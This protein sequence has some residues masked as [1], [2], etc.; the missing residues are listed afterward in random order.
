M[1]RINL[2]PYKGTKEYFQI[3]DVLLKSTEITKDSFLLENGIT[4]S[5]YRLARKQEQNIGKSIIEILSNKFNYKLLQ[6]EK[7]DEIEDKIN[8]IYFDMYYK[9]FKNYDEHIKYLDDLLKENYLIFPILKLMKLFLLL[10]TGKDHKQ[11]E[12][13]LTPIF[14]EIKKYKSFFVSGLDIIY[15]IVKIIL[16]DI[17]INDYILNQYDNGDIYYSLSTQALL[18]QKYMEGLY[19]AN[20]S[21]E[22]LLR[23]GNYKRIIFL[24]LNFFTFYA[25]FKN[26]QDCYDLSKSQLLLL[27]SFKMEDDIKTQTLKFYL[28]SALA[29][30]KY[31]EVIAMIEEKQSMVITEF[32]EYLVALYK[33][34]NDKYLQ[35][36]NETLNDSQNDNETIN[37]CKIMDEYL[38]NNN[39]K[40][41]NDLRGLVLEVFIELLKDK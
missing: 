15:E 2:S 31:D 21:K 13:E 36:L 20:K 9:I 7:L 40:I 29:L 41:L 19:F 6:N 12:E 37:I 17:D 23:D 8:E 26:Y 34:N 1:F 11:Y 27:K 33:T 3:F 38:Q 4:P 32:C 39:K 22:I 16:D 35:T 10:S 14:E 5:S 28:L 25:H 24:N 18:K 30:E